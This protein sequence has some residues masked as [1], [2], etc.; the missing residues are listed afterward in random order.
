M[1]LVVMFQ[2]RFGVGAAE[3]S[4]TVERGFDLFLCARPSHGPPTSLLNEQFATLAI[5]FRSMAQ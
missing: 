4:R 5:V 2:S 3:T 1:K